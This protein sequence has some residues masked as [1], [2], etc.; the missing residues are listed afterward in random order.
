MTDCEFLLAVLQDGRPHTQ[1]ELL[2]LSLES[3]GCGLTIH[4]RVADLRKKGYDVRCTHVPG[5][6]RGRAWA[7]TL[8]EPA[9]PS[10]AGSR[11]A[12]AQPASAVAEAEPC[13]LQLSITEEAA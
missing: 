11:S 3:R 10:P 6:N 7:Y 4:S 5:E 12:H 9:V 1:A 2:K 8:R 13:P